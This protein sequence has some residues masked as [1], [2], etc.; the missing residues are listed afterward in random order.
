MVCATLNVPTGYGPDINREC[1]SCENSGCTKWKWTHNGYQCLECDAGL[2]PTSQSSSYMNYT[3]D[4]TWDWSELNLW[5]YEGKWVEMRGYFDYQGNC[6]DCPSSTCDTCG[7]APLGGS[8]PFW[9][10]CKEGYC[11]N[12]DYNICTEP[13]FTEYYLQSSY[14]A[15]TGAIKHTCESQCETGYISSIYKICFQCD[16]SQF[17]QCDDPNCEMYD[18]DY[19][20]RPFCVSWAEGYIPDLFNDYRWK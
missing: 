3:C 9:Q 8:G 20:G 19:Y 10:G 4:S 18:F 6:F 7:Y 17:P 2:I 16:S 5:M 13:I 11:L 12:N 1:Q 15:T 14:D